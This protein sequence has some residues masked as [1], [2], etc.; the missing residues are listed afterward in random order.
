MSRP[1]LEA[2]DNAKREAV[3]ASRVYGNAWRAGA[4]SIRLMKLK[5]DYEV[6]RAALL[7][8]KGN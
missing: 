7:R 3:E 4:G 8:L 5:H 6:K 2:Y 1:L